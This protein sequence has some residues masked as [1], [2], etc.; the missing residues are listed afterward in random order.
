M[1]DPRNPK[2]KRGIETKEAIAKAGLS[3]FCEQGFYHVDAKQIA[4]AAKVGTGT[5]Y[6]YF[7]DKRDLYIHLLSSFKSIFNDALDAFAAKDLRSLDGCVRELVSTLAEKAREFPPRF[8]EELMVV[9]Y[10]DAEVG[11]AYSGMRRTAMDK[12]V[13]VLKKAGFSESRDVALAAELLLDT[14]EAI[15]VSSARASPDHARALLAEQVDMFIRYLC[16][17]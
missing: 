11:L 16:G 15:L 6:C 7:K 5:F 12:L 9:R 1:R 8:L 14:N 13:A 4:A 10:S 3:L 17:R 2:Q